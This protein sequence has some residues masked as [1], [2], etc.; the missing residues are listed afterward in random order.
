MPTLSRSA[1]NQLEASLGKSRH[2]GS[3]LIFNCPF[4]AERGHVDTKY[5]F[6]LNPEKQVWVCHRCNERGNVRSLFRKLGIPMGEEDFGPPT[7]D[8][9]ENALKKDLHPT[10]PGEDLVNFMYPVPVEPIVPGTLA[11]EYLRARKFDL[12]KITRYGLVWGV[13]KGPRIFIPTYST[14][15]MSYWVARSILKD[16]R[17]PK[18][19]NPTAGKD[20]SVFN[21]SRQRKNEIV[22]C[23]GVFSAMAVGEQGVSIFGKVATAF[24]MKALLQ[25]P[26]TGYTVCLDGDASKENMRLAMALLVSGKPVSY[27]TLS[28]E[29]DPDSVESWENCYSAR[30]PVSALSELSDLLGELSCQKKPN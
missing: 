19:L 30:K 26:V 29:D 28:H 4:C 11:Y 12:E 22:I 1:Q 8:Y 6:Y 21:L 16:E 23:E 25:A 10:P 20:T 7:D 2:A 18:Y 15:G 5:H 9:L 14:S 13:Y 3:E 24:Q 17:S 27:V